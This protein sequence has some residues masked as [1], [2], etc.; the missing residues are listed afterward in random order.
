MLHSLAISVPDISL[1][2]HTYSA[3]PM[4]LKLKRPKPKPLSKKSLDKALM[5]LTAY[6]RKF[7]LLRMKT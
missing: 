7:R 1:I 3:S 5:K 4:R 6:P 2:D